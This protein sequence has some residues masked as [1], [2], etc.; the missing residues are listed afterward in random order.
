MGWLNI[1]SIGSYSKTYLQNGEAY[2]EEIFYIF[3]KRLNDNNMTYSS[4]LEKFVAN[5]GVSTNQFLTDLGWYCQIVDFD[6][7]IILDAVE[8]L[9]YQKWSLQQFNFLLTGTSIPSQKSEAIEKTLVEAKDTVT[10]T[11]SSAADSVSGIV[12]NVVG[13]A[14]NAARS[15]FQLTNILPVIVIGLLL[16]IIFIVYKKG[17]SALKFW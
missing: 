15:L 10:N 3:K 11:I 17:V 6:D 7:D 8:K 2:F 1:F 14:E 16:A 4:L 9:V 12:K 5:S 13:S